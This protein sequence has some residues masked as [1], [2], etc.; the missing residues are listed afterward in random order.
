MVVERPI[1]MEG[2]TCVAVDEKTWLLSG[3]VPE[4]GGAYRR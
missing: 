3:A 4:A 1:A 2:L